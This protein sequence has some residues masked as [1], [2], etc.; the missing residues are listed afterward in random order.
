M[1]IESPWYKLSST[2]CFT[3]SN[4]SLI[5]S[6]S[7]SSQQSS[8]SFESSFGDK[9][10]KQSR[11]S[12]SNRPSENDHKLPET[13]SSNSQTIKNPKPVHPSTFIS[14]ES[15]VA[16]NTNMLKQYS[17]QSFINN[18]NQAYQMSNNVAE[19]YQNSQPASNQ[20]TI[21]LHQN[22]A[23]F[24]YPQNQ[25]QNFSNQFHHTSQMNFTPNEINSDE[26]DDERNRFKNSNSNSFK[27]FYSSNFN[28]N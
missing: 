24:T 9:M 3:G 28:S 15:L 21:N 2:K 14:E 12:P 16:A 13:Q 7:P 20:T 5:S 8:P 27:F 11:L 18:S 25:P 22:S 4:P 17:L 26:S 10:D 6:L 23:H 19:L 1:E